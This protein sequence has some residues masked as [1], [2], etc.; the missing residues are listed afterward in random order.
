MVFVD[1]YHYKISISLGSMINLPN[2]FT[3]ANMLSG[4]I[5]I[6]LAF[7]GRI[8]LAPFAIFTG[9]IFD[10]VDGFLARKLG[11]AGDM[12]KQLDSL[13]DMVT[14]GVAPGMIM[15]VMMSMNL[16]HYL[17]YRM[18]GEVFPETVFTDFFS[19][20][21][22]IAD[23]TE[24]YAIPFFALA[25]PFFS[26]FRLAKFNVDLRQTDKF[27]GL[28]TPA[29]TLFFMTFPLVLCY[30]DLSDRSMILT[31]C[32]PEVLAVLCVTMSFLLIVE[33]PLFALKFKQFGWKGN[34]IR[35]SFLLISAGLIIVFKTWAIALIVFLYLI[36]S[37]LDNLFNK[38]KTDEI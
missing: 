11:V 34:E 37:L 32:Q 33:I 36:L 2:L 35:Y 38:K 15:L 6:L 26:I 7:A 18:E 24:T 13:A 14:F 4:I 3:A 16:H 28:P 20:I 1:I 22:Q 25:I 12:G 8:D 30:G 5:A 17:E 19:Y 31:V 21:N 23:G 27:I 29:N 9:A 10:F